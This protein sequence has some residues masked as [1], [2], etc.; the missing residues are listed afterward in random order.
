MSAAI[1]LSL[2]GIAATLCLAAAMTRHQREL[3]GRALPRRLT[4]L[5]RVTGWLLLASAGVFTMLDRGWTVGLSIWLS[6][7]PLAAIAT[8]LVLSLRNRA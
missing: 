3:F 5:A 2:L 6:L 1:F 4:Q 8:V 7:V